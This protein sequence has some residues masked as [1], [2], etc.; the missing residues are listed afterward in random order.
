[1]HFHQRL[2]AFGKRGLSTADRPKQIED[3]LALFEALRRMAGEADDTLDGS[4][5]PWKPAKAG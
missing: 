5:M 2:E 3:L 4:S 1:M